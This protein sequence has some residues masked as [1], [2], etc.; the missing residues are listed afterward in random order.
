MSTPYKIQY[1]GYSYFGPQ[2]Q[3][4]TNTEFDA[5]E[6]NQLIN[7]RQYEDAASYASQFRFD[8]PDM[9]KDFQSQIYTLKR[10][11]RKLN[12]IYSKIP[13][14]KL[15][16]IEFG[17]KVLVNGGLETLQNNPYAD[18]FIKYKK[19]LGSTDEDE[20]TSLSVTFEP[21]KQTFLGIDW[22]NP[23]NYN[24][25]TAF[26]E[27]SGFN[28]QQLRANGITVTNKD[29][30]TT[31]TFDKSHRFANKIL[32]N[33]N[34][35]SG[36]GNMP[37]T[38]TGHGYKNNE[39]V[40]LDSIKY[41]KDNATWADF[42]L[43]KDK[44]ALVQ[45]SANSD[46]TNLK[47]LIQDAKDEKEQYFIDI[48]QATKDYSTT[49]AGPLFDNNDD[50]IELQQKAAQGLISTSDY[51]KALN[52]NKGYVRDALNAIGS[53]N[54]DMY[55]NTFNDEATDETL[56]AA[57]NKSRSEL[58]QYLSSRD[59]KDVS[60]FAGYCNGKVGTYIS[61]AAEHK[62]K[63]DSSFWDDILPGDKLS[64]RRIQVF[65]PGLFE[66]E[67]QKKIDSN[68]SFRAVQE[69]SEMESWGYEYSTENNKKLI[70]DGTGG[71]IDTNTG[72]QYTR[73]QAIKEI[74]KD[75][76]KQD[77]RLNLQYKFI[78]HDNKLPNKAG[79]EQ[80][81]RLIAIKAGNDLEPE[82]SL[83]DTNGKLYSINN[84]F[85]MMSLLGTPAFNSHDMNY[86]V[87]NK[88]NDIFEIYTSIMRD[89]SYYNE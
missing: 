89:I 65:I 35:A 19:Q 84:V 21:R 2:P 88:L 13:E 60:L 69:V 71:F 68:T 54:Y 75:Y 85:S 16:L 87:Y 32:Y 31:L 30:R 38:I 52:L 81:A 8:D 3:S 17:D 26:Y 56:I 86:E 59:A 45:A 64:T 9:Q 67:A 79:Y 41:E 73:Q 78:T 53:G 33:L 6:F 12:A 24:D 37:V 20:A 15:P 82:I 29:G 25:I 34:D 49:I 40:D 22:L 42:M 10:E 70:S 63:D 7:N 48:N 39:V 18:K 58:I 55:T 1:D 27:R 77:S 76:I 5:D 43:N 28:E 50:M 44:M 46:I 72:Q 74:N 23:D 62:T 47:R 83:A 11:G 4:G 66:K 80:M 57:D 61:V 14:D 51:N 36:Y